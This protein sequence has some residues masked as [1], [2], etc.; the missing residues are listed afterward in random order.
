M[1]TPAD[2]WLMRPVRLSEKAWNYVESRRGDV[3]VDDY[4]SRL[5]ENVA[6][7]GGE[8]NVLPEGINMIEVIEAYRPGFTFVDDGCQKVA[9]EI[10]GYLREAYHGK[11]P[12]VVFRKKCGERG[13]ASEEIAEAERTFWQWL[14]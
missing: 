1:G 14:Y 13:L 10:M 6:D 5:I 4:V 2:H 3:L 7:L 8:G 11:V 12:L 9:S